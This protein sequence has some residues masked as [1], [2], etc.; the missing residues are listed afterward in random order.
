MVFGGFP[1]FGQQQ[2][3]G[4]QEALETVKYD[5]SSKRKSAAIDGVKKSESYLTGKT[6]DKMTSICRE[7]ATCSQYLADIKSSLGP[8][9]AALKESQDALQGSE[10]ERSALDKAYN[11]Q[12]KATRIL[13]QLQEQMVP[14]NYETP[15]PSEYADLPQLKK[16]ATVEMIVKKADPGAQFD[17]EGVNY[18]EAKMVM[19]IDGYTGKCGR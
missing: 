11:S 8:L 18:P 14:A 19:V 12:V 4:L 5:I 13:T 2:A 10:Q 17:V 16:R 9:T 1:A 3:R 6:A 15:V 7:P